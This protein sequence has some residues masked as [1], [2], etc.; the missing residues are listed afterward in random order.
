MNIWQ[1]YN[2]FYSDYLENVSTSSINAK[3]V[4]DL[5]AGYLGDEQ[6]INQTLFDETLASSSITDK[7]LRIIYNTI[8]HTLIK[9]SLNVE[10]DQIIDPTNSQVKLDILGLLEDLGYDIEPIFKDVLVANKLDIAN[11]ISEEFN[12]TK[13]S[14]YAI[15]NHYVD[16]SLTVQ[17]MTNFLNTIDV[18]VADIFNTIATSTTFEEALKDLLSTYKTDIVPF[19]TTQIQQIPNLN[20]SE[21]SLT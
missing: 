15:I 18:T 16:G 19:L 21:E 5:V 3:A 7:N 1:S 4:I 14:V 6:T 20:I 13:L 17:E 10:K 11:A 8:F 2:N 9:N 12:I